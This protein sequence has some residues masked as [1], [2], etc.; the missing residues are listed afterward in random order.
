MRPHPR[1]RKT[2]KWGGAVVCALLLVVW[3]ESKWYIASWIST[4][5]LQAHISQ[6]GLFLM[7]GRLSEM[8]YSQNFFEL[9]QYSEV[10]CWSVQWTTCPGIT[11][12]GLPLWPGVIVAL[13]ITLAAW[14][15]DRIAW[16]EA[17]QHLCPKCNYSRTGLAP[18]AVCPECGIGSKSAAD[19]RG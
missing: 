4:H 19:Q 18:E 10:F 13:A 6:G 16:F 3:I 11:V 1:I 17:R 15:L 8:P 2:V 9:R 12:I 14:R 7:F 5:D